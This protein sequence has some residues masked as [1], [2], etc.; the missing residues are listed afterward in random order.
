[1]CVLHFIKL[2]TQYSW[3][4]YFLEAFDSCVLNV[5]AVLGYFN[6]LHLHQLLI[7]FVFPPTSVVLKAADVLQSLVYAAC[8]GGHLLM[9]KR[10]LLPSLDVNQPVQLVTSLHDCEH[11]TPL[12]AAC[13]GVRWIIVAVGGYLLVCVCVCVCVC[14]CVCIGSLLLLGVACLCVC[15]CVC[16]CVCALDN[17][18]YWGLLACLCVCAFMCVR[19][20]VCVRVTLCLCVCVYVLH[21]VC[22]CECVYV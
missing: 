22:M 20:C 14:L 15:V 9:V 3:I 16:V 7:V 2:S 8:M 4:I 6:Q 19:A 18:C 1:M 21:C 12:H 5:L 10:W 17:Y 11:R 13:Q